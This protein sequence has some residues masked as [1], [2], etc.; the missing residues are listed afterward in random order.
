MTPAQLREAGETLAKNDP[1]TYGYGWYGWQTAL[2]R[3]LG[4][5]PR[6]VRA[7]L[8]G[9]NPISQSVEMLVKRL[10]EESGR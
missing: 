5:N 3:I 9:R 8:S 1:E 7:W 4:Y 6:T 2:A 10:V